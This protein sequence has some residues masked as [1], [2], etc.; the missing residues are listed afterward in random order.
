MGKKNEIVS[1]PKTVV[2]GTLAGW[3]MWLFSKTLRVKVVD[4][5][6]AGDPARADQPMILVMWHNRVFGVPPV[7]ARH[8]R[9]HRQCVALTSA[10]KD[11]EM[12]A[13]ALGFF[14]IGA[15][16]GSSSRRGAVALVALKRAL[17]EGK[18]VCITPDGP[19]GPIYEVQ[20]GVVKLAESSGVPLV[21][22]SASF[23]SAWRLK[24]WDRFVIPKPFSRIEVRF[25]KP[26]HVEKGLGKEQLDAVRQKLEARL[27]AEVDDAET[28]RDGN[29]TRD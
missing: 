2:V 4:E 19:K 9:K 16:R 20:P 23:S 3:L 12:V 28:G 26:I 22:L 5:A 27:V 8:C 15:V 21:T 1:T 24:T 6:G 14:G 29:S 18:D 25:G 7:W 17:K 11:G 10:S 13:R